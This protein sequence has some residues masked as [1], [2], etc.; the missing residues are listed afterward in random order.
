MKKGIL[1]LLVLIGMAQL[2]EAAGLPDLIVVKADYSAS[3]KQYQKYVCS[4]T[5]ENIGDTAI[6]KLSITNLY[7]S[8]DSIF[9]SGDVYGGFVRLDSLK[10]NEQITLTVIGGANQF[11]I[12]A[13]S[14]YRYII[15][16][17][18][19]RAEVKEK[20]EQNNLW[21]GL[22]SIVNAKVDLTI[23]S[24]T[25]NSPDNIRFGDV[26]DVTIGFV[27]NGSDNVQNA[28]YEY[29]LS[30]DTILDESDTKIGSLNWVGFN[31]T[32]TGLKRDE[33]GLST[34]L[35]PGSYYLFVRI[36]SRGQEILIND[37]NFN[38]NI[39]RLDKLNIDKS[40]ENATLNFN[41]PFGTS[42]WIED[43]HSWSWDNTGWDNIRSYLP[44][45]GSGHAMSTDGYSSKLSTT[46]L[47]NITGLWL[48][49]DFGFNF[50]HL[51]ILGY[52]NSGDTI[53]SKV[54]DPNIYS[55]DY[56]YLTLNWEE[57][58]SI[59]FDY[60][61][62]DK[63]IPIDLFYDDMDYAFLKSATTSATEISDNIIKVFPNPS[64]GIF[65]VSQTGAM[66][67][68]SLRIVDLN[69]RVIVEERKISSS[70]FP[71]DI[72]DKPSGVYFVELF[73]ERKSKIVKI[74]KR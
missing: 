53:Y 73:A 42:S 17:A 64:N 38:N 19:S 52:N 43:G 41:E 59:Q 10:L 34:T 48:K 39:V 67:Y 44:C 61:S 74:Y 50:D 70:A 27:N 65:N 63:M 57:V 6:N 62:K 21:S 25:K 31:W 9:D 23:K 2:T 69:G 1:I 22:V 20:D 54:L 40:V 58:K 18:D 5:L 66:G 56:L 13:D 29:F 30:P 3:Q 24:F 4:V 71:L 14:T 46:S 12:N 45:T 15:V 55:Q 68:T 49:V 37:F 35:A 8:K 47:L 28:M 26:L 72:S 60:S 51:K 33:L 11:G 16:K 7:F 32:K 36:N